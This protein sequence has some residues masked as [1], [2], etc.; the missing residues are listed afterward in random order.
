MNGLPAGSARRARGFTLIELLVVLVILGSLIGL[1]VLGTGLA[2]PSRELRGEAER[3]AGLIGVLADEAVLDN[4][5]YGLSF[6][7][8]GYRVLRYD[9]RRGEWQALDRQAHR[10][11]DWAEL[12]V[13]VEGEAFSLPGAAGAPA[14]QLLILSSGEF[15]PFRLRLAE[16]RRDGLQLQLSSDGFGLPRIEELAAGRAG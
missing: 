1:A 14:P 3:L 5:E 16:R 2:G 6:T 10:L 13:E 8:E 15:T 11:P 9:P 4:R 7:R 12:D